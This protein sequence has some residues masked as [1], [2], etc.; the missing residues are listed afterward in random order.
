MPP[1]G[2]PIQKVRSMA[3]DDQTPER[4]AYFALVRERPELF[5][6][7]EG[8]AAIQLAPH[9]VCAVES[10]IA[11]RLVLQGLPADWA[12][13]GVYYHDPYV[14]LIR[15]A[16]IQPDGTP[17]IHHRVLSP[18]MEPVT[19]AAMLPRFNGNIVL[20]RHYRHPTRAFH[21]E[22]PR[23]RLEPG[24]DTAETARRELEEEIG[25]TLATLTPLGII[26]PNTALAASAVVGYFA[27]LSAIG[28][29]QLAEGIVEVM[30][31][32]PVD[33]DCLVANGDITDA[34]TLALYARAKAR[35]LL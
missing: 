5:V 30:M 14:V 31:L 1:Y 7:P 26:H 9:D 24:Q 10:A 29:P 20:V 13:V 25:G 19:G 16:I 27:E 15:D 8:G 33:V 17:A 11:A 28:Q 22:A 6:T 34:M 21:L 35:C 32:T 23:G 3:V 4:K 18:T 12:Q 2:A